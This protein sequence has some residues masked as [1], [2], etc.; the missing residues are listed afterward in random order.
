M[1]GSGVCDCSVCFGRGSRPFTDR[2]SNTW[3]GCYASHCALHSQAERLLNNIWACVEARAGVQITH[4]SLHFVSLA[5][6]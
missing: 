6:Q 1:H 4:G 3:R 2:D 5:M